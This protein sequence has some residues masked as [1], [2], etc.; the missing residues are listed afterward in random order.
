MDNGFE[1]APL[2]PTQQFGR[3]NEFGEM[4]SGKVAPFAVAAENIVDGNV[5]MP[6]LVKARQHV[7]SDEA[8]PAGDQQHRRRDT[9]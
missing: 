9:A 3:R 4:S 1:F 8:G 7:R 6:G 5:A 2:K